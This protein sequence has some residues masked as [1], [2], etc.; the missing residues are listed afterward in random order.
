MRAMKMREVKS[1]VKRH[2]KL[3]GNQE[4]LFETVWPTVGLTAST[5]V[6]NF[7]EIFARQAPTIC[8]IGFGHGDT[9]SVMA[10]ENPDK[11]YLG[12]EVHEPGVAEVLQFIADHDLK[13]IR[14]ISQD[15]VKIFENNIPD[16]S[17]S[18]I[19]ICFPDPWHKTRHHKRRLVNEKFVAL[20]VKKLV[21]GGV[22]H[23]A[24][25]WE[26]YAEQM[27][28]VLS[29]NTLLKN[30]MGEHQFVNNSVLK[31][32]ATTKFERRGIKLGHG[33]WDLVFQ[34]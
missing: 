9:L 32:R 30:T 33:V 21:P 5:A 3:T 12:M 31:L 2:R 26:N 4:K 15:A 18:R 25:D 27:M 14:I 29:E 23:C 13:N 11:N 16:E 1:F 7:D 8:E 6:F 19:H 10:Q 28:R 34:K 22:I 20:M 24:T 17:L